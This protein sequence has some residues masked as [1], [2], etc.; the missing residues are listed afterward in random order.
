MN[1]MANSREFHP[2]KKKGIQNA[3]VSVCKEQKKMK[4]T[5]DSTTIV[6]LNSSIMMGHDCFHKS[7]NN[8]NN[9][10]H[11][12]LSFKRRRIQMKQ[13]QTLLNNNS[14]VGKDVSSINHKEKQNEKVS[15]AVISSSLPSPATVSSSTVTCTKSAWDYGNIKHLN[16]LNFLKEFTGSNDGKTKKHSVH[17]VICFLNG[18]RIM[19]SL[20][21][22]NHSTI[23]NLKQC[24]FRKT[25]IPIERQMLLFAGKYLSNNNMKIEDSG[26]RE[27]S[28]IQIVFPFNSC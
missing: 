25:N 28:F 2:P 18:R 11:M 21:I 22:S 3:F 10:N 1:I 19:V 5:L 27:G 4:R 14:G 24:I 8:N 20:D 7:T 13:E 16:H 6:E 17:F 23:Y 9:N 26:L 15:D 12:C